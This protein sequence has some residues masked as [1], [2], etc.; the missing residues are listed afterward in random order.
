MEPR[1]VQKM[2]LQECQCWEI[3][4]SQTTPKSVDALLF[5]FL[6]GGGKGTIKRRNSMESRHVP[7]IGQ[8]SYCTTEGATR[9]QM[10][11]DDNPATEKVDTQRCPDLWEARS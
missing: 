6:M 2:E 3:T 7:K 4:P 11:G 9:M 8:S 10:L 1:N 5:S